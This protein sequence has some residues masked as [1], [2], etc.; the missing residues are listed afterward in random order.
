MNLVSPQ[1]S[2]SS[3]DVSPSTNCHIFQ[4]IVDTSSVTSDDTHDD[5]VELMDHIS[6]LS[7]HDMK[8]NYEKVKEN[9]AI[10]DNGNHSPEVQKK[11]DRERRREEIRKRNEEKKKQRDLLKIEKKTGT[12][13]LSFKDGP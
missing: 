9:N 13:L 12:M 10:S 8:S 4:K 7:M 6:N 1:D 5:P 11:L 3:Y 2:F